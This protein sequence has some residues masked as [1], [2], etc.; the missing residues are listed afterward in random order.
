[1]ITVSGLSKSYGG[2]VLYQNGSFFI[3][4]GEKVGLVGPNGAGKTSLFRLIIGDERPESGSINIPSGLR[5]CY[6]SQN[7]G[8]LKGR[9]AIEEVIHGNPRLGFLKNEISKIVLA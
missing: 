9:S 6:F 3:G 8:E 7:V 4:P 2:Q 5:L 1:M